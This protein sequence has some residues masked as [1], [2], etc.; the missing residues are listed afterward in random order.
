MQTKVGTAAQAKSTPGSDWRTN[1]EFVVMLLMGL[2]MI[3]DS[4]EIMCFL[5]GA[6]SFIPEGFQRQTPSL[7]GPYNAVVF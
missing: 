5:T 3:L 6:F 7:T 4:D 2:A 1:I